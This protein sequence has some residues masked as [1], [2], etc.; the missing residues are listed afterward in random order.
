MLQIDFVHV[1]NCFYDYDYDYYG[2]DRLTLTLTLTSDLIF[3]GCDVS[4]WTIPVPSLA[5][6]VS[7][8]LVLSCGQTDRI[9]DADDGYTHVT[10]IGVSN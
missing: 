3:I 4:R 6:L 1:T 5:I 9:T 7:A 8:I 2:V 10:T